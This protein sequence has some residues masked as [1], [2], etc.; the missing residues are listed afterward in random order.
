MRRA[1]RFTLALAWAGVWVSG[2]AHGAEPGDFAWRRDVQGAI[3]PGGLYRV[4]LDAAVVDGCRAFPD[5][6]RLFDE[7]GQAW[8][9]YLWVPAEQIVDQPVAAERLNPSQAEAPEP[10]RRVDLQLAAAPGGAR[11]R[12]DSV[13]I[14]TSGRDFI[15]RAEVYGAD[16][17]AGAWARVG[18]GYLVDHG[19]G[20]P[21]ASREIRYPVCDYP[22]L[23]VRIYPTTRNAAEEFTV[24]AV[25]PRLAVR[26]PGEWR[27][28]AARE[29][30]AGR[31][32]GRPGT[33]VLVFDTGARGCPLER[34]AVAARESN[35]VRAARVYL[36]DAPEEDWRWV[37]A[38]E[39]HRV[40]W[41]A[42]HEVPLGRARGRFVKI[43]LDH[44]DDPPLSGLA[45]RLQA[46][47]RYLVTEAGAGRRPALYYGAGN[48]GPSQFD[49]ARRVTAAAVQAAPV[50]RLAAATLGSGGG[51]TFWERHAAALS[52]VAVGLAAVVV[53]GVVV[54]LL[55]RQAETLRRRPGGD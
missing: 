42:Q 31:Q 3:T 21:V 52:A 46:A 5:D 45:V 25:T 44:H 30:A 43:E 38:G 2:A 35:Y 18:W 54:S 53:L 12:H 9:F 23:Q 24:L 20:A 16:A 29:V 51:S 37:A 55:R 14:V 7:T 32:D 19:P 11:A 15:R 34:V 1:R 47:P 27:D 33:Q 28:L 36:R 10:Y 50:L 17:E 26:S 49:L 48:V 6:L 22:R 41:E 40:D 8:P 4:E 13:E 39:L